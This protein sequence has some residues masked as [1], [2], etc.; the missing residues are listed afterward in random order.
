MMRAETQAEYEYESSEY[1]YESSAGVLPMNPN[2]PVCY[3]LHLTS[4]L[5]NANER[6]K[7][8]CPH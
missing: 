1:E 3:V 7:I 8:D 6:E 5:F 4:A 2:E